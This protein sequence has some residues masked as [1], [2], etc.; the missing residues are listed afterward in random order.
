MAYQ[1]SIAAPAGAKHSP[2]GL[3]APSLLVQVFC[4][5]AFLFFAGALTHPLGVGS[6]DEASGLFLII[7][8]AFYCGAGLL[9]LHGNYRQRFFHYVRS[10]PAMLLGLAIMV[11]SCLWSIDPER[12][13]RRSIAVVGTSLAGVLIGL[14]YSRYQ[15]VGFI[16]SN[17]AVFVV[18]SVL[19]ALLVPSLGTHTEEKLGLW[20]GLM[21][22]KNQMA[23][24]A[25]LF[26]IF[27]LSAASKKTLSNPIFLLIAAGGALLLYKAGSATGMLAT[28]VG[29][30]FLVFLKQYVAHQK[31]RHPML[32]VSFLGL[33]VLA[34]LW[35]TAVET[36][37]ELVG[38][39]S[40][41]TGRTSIW[42]AMWP[43]IEDRIWLGY[44]YS[45]FW[46]DPVRFFGADNWMSGM[47]HSHSAYIEVLIDLGV[48]GVAVQGAFIVGV[49][50]QLWKLVRDGDP[51]GPPLLAALL[52]LLMIGLVGVLF[53]RPNAG[54]WVMIV[55]FSAYATERQRLYYRERGE[56][57]S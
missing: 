32:V 19:L 42:L 5:A 34:L 52:T 15:L 8:G 20:R 39:S 51:H 3:V 30:F 46:S 2:D 10:N 40:T 54:T 33:A 57:S 7:A 26:L 22:S 56:H 43:L 24:I 53:F 1:D 12:T 36:S 45:A 49:L 48:V 18:L 25:A 6:D 44:G 16:R 21:S 37:L 27:W 38:R 13:L 23:W 50:V 17:L 35:Q 31:V 29:L 41:L 28:L 9:L 55:A 4:C 14:A 11:V 47:I